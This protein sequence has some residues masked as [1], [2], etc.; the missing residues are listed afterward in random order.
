LSAADRSLSIARYSSDAKGT[1]DDFVRTSKNGTFLLARDFMEYH[2]HRFED[3]SLILRDDG[4]ILAL[5]PANRSGDELH[6]HQGLTYGGL[7]TGEAMTTPIMLDL[8]EHLIVYLRDHGTRRLHYKTIPSIYHRLPAEED[9][10]ALFRAGARLSRRDVLSVIS[11]RIRAPV[12]MRRRRGAAKAAAHGV[13][14]AEASDWAGF[15]SVLTDHLASL[16]GVPPVHSLDEINLLRARFPAQLRLFQALKGSEVLGGVVIFESALVAHVQ[17]IASS[18][19]GRELAAL[20]AVFFHLLD[21][22]FC[23]K[24]F[25]DFGI[26]NEEGGRHLNRGLIEQKEGFGARAVVHDF[27]TLE[28]DG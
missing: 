28:I 4:R 13:T 14:V 1:W 26:S 12:Q 7:I 22:V 18:G 23:E 15:W 19:A 27:Y 21:R 17:Y 10:Y 3:H 6:S 25:F 20:D 5:L 9:R 24:A 16:Y 8:F 2:C 11:G